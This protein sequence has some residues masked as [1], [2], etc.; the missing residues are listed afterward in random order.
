MRLLKLLSCSLLLAN[1]DKV[2]GGPLTQRQDGLAIAV[3]STSP[4]ALTVSDGQQHIKNAAIL[5]GDTNKTAIPVPASK[6]GVVSRNHGRI[7]FSVLNPEVAKV[8]VDTTYKFVGTQFKAS[9]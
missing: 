2:Y 7:S 1:V 8:A 6:K 9:A 5:A 3:S 4:F